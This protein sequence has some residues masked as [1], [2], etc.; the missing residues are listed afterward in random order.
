VLSVA[1]LSPLFLLTHVASTQVV[2]RQQLVDSFNG[3]PSLFAFLLSTRA[4]GQGLNLTGADTVI[5]HD[6]DFNPQV[7][8]TTV[9][10][11]QPP[12]EHCPCACHSTPR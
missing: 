6:V 4:G 7:S 8:S 1:P 11:I 5:L 12:G 2:E 9:P 10:A 3:D